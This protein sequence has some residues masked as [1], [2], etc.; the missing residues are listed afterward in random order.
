MSADTTPAEV[1][2]ALCRHV[3]ETPIEMP[4]PVSLYMLSG[5]TSA[6]VSIHMY[7]VGRNGCRNVNI[8]FDRYVST[9]VRTNSDTNVNVTVNT[10]VSTD[11]SINVGT[12]TPSHLSDETPALREPKP[13]L[14]YA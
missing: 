12:N 5:Q 3:R 4:V 8:S 9:N 1:P 10:D 6:Q 2:R 14:P 13:L 11:V 7:N